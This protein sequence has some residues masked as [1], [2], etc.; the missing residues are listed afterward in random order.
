MSLDFKRI[1][2]FIFPPSEDEVT[3]RQCN[4]LNIFICNCDKDLISLS[5]YT[6]KT[7]RA[8]IHLVK[9]HNQAKAKLL[10]S[11]VLKEYLLSRIHESIIL[12]P[13]PLGKK[14]LRKRGFNQVAEVAKLIL[15][16]APNIKLAN[17]ILVR[18]RET[19]PQTT[20]DKKAR[21]QNMTKAFTV[22]NKEQSEEIIINKHVIIL[23]DVTTTGATLK[24]A[25][26]A[27]L[28]LHPASITCVA[29]AH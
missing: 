17:N 10:L 4:C 20:L 8:A 19:V 18:Q 5:N 12:I 15:Q 26:A 21:L 23:D 14:R 25:K 1:L 22:K 29:L 6:D 3:I 24:A 13:I 11:G 28:P 16:D 2:D 7:V 27:L 9:Y